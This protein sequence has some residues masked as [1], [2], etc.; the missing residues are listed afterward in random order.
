MKR[1]LVYALLG[2]PIGWAVLFAMT[3]LFEPRMRDTFDAS[4]LGG[5][6]LLIPFSY[7]AGLLPAIIVAV[8]DLLLAKRRLALRPRI[9]ACTAAGYVVAILGMYGFHPP[10][11]GKALVFGLVGAIPAAVCAWLSGRNRTE[12]A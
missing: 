6:V 12:P 11:T 3:V 9:G 8:V 2:P 1:F 5:A 10:P 4:T 7:L